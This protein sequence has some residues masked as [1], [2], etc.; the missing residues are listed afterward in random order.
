MKANKVSVHAKM[1]LSECLPVVCSYWGVTP[2]QVLSKSRLRIIINARHSLRYFLMMTQDLSLC[3]VGAL[4]DSDHATILH[5]KKTFDN[6]C[7]YDYRFREMKKI[8][9]GDDSHIKNYSKENLLR[10]IVVSGLTLKEK[11][12]KIKAIYEH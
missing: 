5:S 8:M 6:L 4:T 9:L 10:N 2:K 1:R 11:V 12:D 3:E 7:I